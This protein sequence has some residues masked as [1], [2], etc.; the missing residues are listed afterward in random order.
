MLIPFPLT[1]LCNHISQQSRTRRSVPPAY[2]CDNHGTSSRVVGCL[3]ELQISLTSRT[4]HL[5]TAASSIFH[6]QG[7]TMPP[8][9]NFSTLAKKDSLSDE[10]LCARCCNTTGEQ[11]GQ[12]TSFFFIYF[13]IAE[14]KESQ[15]H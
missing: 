2:Q 15:N 9:Q 13:N 3:Q 8:S 10:K 6:V 5:Q 4:Q 14:M 11:L 1:V 7:L 12:P